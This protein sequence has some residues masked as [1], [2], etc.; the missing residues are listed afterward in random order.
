MRRNSD[1]ERLFEP[2]TG[3]TGLEE[4]DHRLLMRLI[5]ACTGLTLGVFSVLQFLA[6]NPWLSGIEVIA[7]GLLLW[8]SQRLAR[9]QRLVPWILAYLLPTFCFILYIIVMP[10]ASATAFVW[11]YLMPVMA[12]LLLGKVHG[13]LLAVPFMA[14]ATGL[15]LHV[16]QV[17]VDATGLIDIG[18]GIFCGLLV[19]AF[20]HVYES[21]RAD[22]YKQLRHLALTDAL[23]GVASRES[24]Q[25]ALQ[26]C[27]Q[28]AARYDTR[29][30]LVV[31]DVDHFKCVNDQWGHDA[32]DKA[33]QHLC[34]CLRHRLRAT[35]LIGRLGGEE[36]GILLPFT[37]RFDAQPLVEA[38]RQ[39]VARIPMDYLG[40]R[41]HL[42]ATFG[43]AEWPSDGLDAAE[44]YRCT[45]RRLYRGKAE[46][47]NRLV[48]SDPA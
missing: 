48:C 34:K 22:A 23:T 21:R 1:S 46:G 11:V 37:D 10:N 38:L 17:R 28:E 25:R 45:D 47:R 40:Q 5:F 8:A 7:C 43:L 27:I 16:N 15:Y 29:L 14:V 26:R 9:V 12:Y 31:L 20:M 35:D 44:L 2:S 18:N 24:F 32:G 30:V 36:F 33:L 39:E 4:A 13:F 3:P 19:I 42:S 41:I 6:G